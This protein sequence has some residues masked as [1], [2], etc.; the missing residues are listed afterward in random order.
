[1]DI[2]LAVLVLFLGTLVSSTFGFGGALF[3]MPLL[4][5]AIGLPTATPLFGLVGFL[6]ALTITSTSWRAI[7]FKLVWR[8]VGTT[9][10]GIPVGVWLVRVMAGELLIHGLGTFL[11]LF[12]LYRLTPIRLP[13]IC[14][15]AWAYPFGFVAGI[16]GGAY[17]T[18][19][20]PIVIYGSMNRWP[21]TIFRATLQSYFLPTGIAILTSHALGGLWTL[22]VFILLA[23]S[24]PGVFL[25]IWLGRFL[26]QR[27]SVPQFDRALYLLLIGLGILL[28]L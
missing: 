2:S 13:L 6:T 18:N 23:W 17:N 10:L 14:H 4:T 1:M 11:I 19:G 27:F 5:L 21:P 24:L 12:G 8:L 16:L 15:P 25:A 28:W 22:K 9:M 7:Q 26:N 3:S 20:P